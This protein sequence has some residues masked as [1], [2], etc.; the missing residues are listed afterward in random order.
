MSL[1][2]GEAAEVQTLTAVHASAGSIQNL[3][4][5]KMHHG[6]SLS[7]P[8]VPDLTPPPLVCGPLWEG[9]RVSV[10]LLRLVTW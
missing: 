6:P 7:L 8:A 2:S 1:P 9:E 4:F 5:Q 3:W 10:L